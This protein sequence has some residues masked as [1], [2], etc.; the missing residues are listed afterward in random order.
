MVKAVDDGPVSNPYLET[1][2]EYVSTTTGEIYNP[3]I[4][5]SIKK[6]KPKGDTQ[7]D[8]YIDKVIEKGEI[9]V[10]NTILRNNF[11]TLQNHL[12]SSVGQGKKTCL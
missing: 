8:V 1:E 5:S 3:E 10:S 6:I 7:A 9:L 4:F 11:Y 2:N 12:P